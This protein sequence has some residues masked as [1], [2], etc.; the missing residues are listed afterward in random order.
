MS[1]GSVAR[2]EWAPW[3]E[4]ADQRKCLRPSV[5][6]GNIRLRCKTCGKVEIG[7]R[8]NIRGKE[9]AD[10]C[11]LCNKMSPAFRISQ[12]GWNATA[13]RDAAITL[14]THV[15]RPTAPVERNLKRLILQRVG[16]AY[17][18]ARTADSASY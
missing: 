12:I 18:S 16:R 10:N 15:S 2:K 7:N 11:F 5:E 13:A 6:V 9:R 1:G 4:C 17:G 8:P 3:C 14:M